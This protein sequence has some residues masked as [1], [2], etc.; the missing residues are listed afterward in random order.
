MATRLFGAAIL[1][2]FTAPVLAAAEAE[3]LALCG[4]CLNPTV[5][6]KTGVG[7][8]QAM[9]EARVTREAAQAWCANWQPD[10]KTCLKQQLSGEQNK[11]YRASADCLHGR[12]RAVDGNAYGLAGFWTS[13][14]GRGRSK[15]K[16]ADGSVVGQDEASGGL[17]LAQ[18]WELLYPGV[19]RITSGQQAGAAGTQVQLAQGQAPAQPAQAPMAESQSLPMQDSAAQAPSAFA[20]VDSPPA[21]TSA[22]MPAASAPAPACAAPRCFNAGAFTATLTQLVEGQVGPR[23]EAAVRIGI[24]FRNTGT[25][26][27]VLAYAAG[28]ST[29]VDSVGSHFT[30]G[31][32]NTPDSSAQGIGKVEGKN[33]DTRFVL[34]PG[35]ARDALFQLLKD[36]PGRAA[37]AGGTRYNYAV[38][39]AQLDV[40]GNQVRLARAYRLGFQGIGPGVDASSR[41]AGST[42]S[43]SISDAVKDLESAAKKFGDLFE[44]K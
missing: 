11:V 32:P 16:G 29:L 15:W 44:K 36:R 14:V 26:P 3:W 6:A 10:D 5:T 17:A 34:A 30:I 20:P 21:N 27:L 28:S 41:P 38:G 33:A 42:S 39:I 35:E 13:E 1:L 8:E 40:V 7:T 31:P 43:A 2:A 22:Q 9:A 18:Q 23:R 19:T 25:Q 37:A 24:T 4:K 12:L